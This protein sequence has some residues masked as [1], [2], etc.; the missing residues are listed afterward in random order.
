MTQI[1]IS[2][3]P[4]EGL[5]LS[6]SEEAAELDLAVPGARFLQPI[7]V[8]LVLVK[9]AG[10]ISAHGRIK[11]SVMCECVRCLSQFPVPLDIL[12]AT[13]F[14]PALPPLPPGEYRMPSEE[15]EDYYYQDDVVV[16]DDHIVLVIVILGL[17]G[18]HPIFPRRQGR[19]RRP[20][21]CRDQ[22][23]QGDRKLAQTP[24][25]LAH[26]R[27]LDA[28]VG[29]DLSSGLH[30][31]Q[32]HRDRLQEARARDGEI[33]LGRLLAVGHG[34]PLFRN[35]RDRDLGHGLDLPALTLFRKAHERDRPRPLDGDRQLS[36]MPQ[37]IA[38]HPARNDPTPFGQEVAQQAD[39]LIIN[40]D[41]FMAETAHTPALKTSSFHDPL[42]F[43]SLGR[44]VRLGRRRDFVERFPHGGLPALIHP[45]GEESDGLRHD[46]V[47]GDL[48]PVLRLE[49]AHLEAAFDQG[50][51]PLAEVLAAGLRLP[52]EDD[53]VHEADFFLGFVPLPVPAIDRQ[54]EI[55]DRRPAGRIPDLWVPGK[56]SHED[57]FI[58]PRHA[59]ALWRVRSRL[60]SA[61]C[62]RSSRSD[63]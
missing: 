11:T 51:V 18:R 26:D 31:D 21:L 16:L 22:D 61:W 57:D 5:P 53:D 17:L 47:L 19:Q 45:L 42:P 62:P 7:A 33:E 6:Y 30:K 50:A 59:P 60:D 34:Q 1:P 38:R 2:E 55:G 39:I 49:L 37:A 3:I 15:A 23:V 8:D 4:E 52:A 20:E 43:S 10:E 14:R 9:A 40:G 29:A 58:E 41:L 12:V 46:L 13:Q 56:V 48:L 32:V 27:R 28:P 25:A 36:L 54:P 44:L 35:L 63:T 24:D